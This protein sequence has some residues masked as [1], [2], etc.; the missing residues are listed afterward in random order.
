VDGPVVEIV[1]NELYGSP[2]APLDRAAQL[3]K[4]H[5]CLRFGLGDN[6]QERAE[7]LIDRIDRLEQADNVSEIAALAAGL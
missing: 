2:A 4:F 1:V 6:A 3:E 7:E 5:A